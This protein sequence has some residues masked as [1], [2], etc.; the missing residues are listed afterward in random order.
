VTEALP[1]LHCCCCIRHV[2]GI[3]WRHAAHG[4]SLRW[5][6]LPPRPQSRQRPRDKILNIFVEEDY[7][8]RIAWYRAD[9][10]AI[11]TFAGTLKRP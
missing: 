3:S 2:E 8:L 4:P 7:A 9:D 10:R 6:P 11:E 5:R 1:T